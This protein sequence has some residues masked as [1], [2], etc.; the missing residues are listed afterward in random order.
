VAL[1]LTFVYAG[2]GAPGATTV[3]VTLVHITTACLWLGGLATL[4][5]ALVPSGTT[6]GLATALARFSFIAPAC[7]VVLAA[8]G[9]VHA[10]LR[11]GSAGRLFTTGYGHAY[12]LKVAAVVAM[13]AVA[14]GNRRYVARH[15]RARVGPDTAPSHVLG[16]YLGA[17]VAFGLLVVVLTGTLVDAPVT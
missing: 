10:V 4:A 1:A 16:L 7:V 15:V 12:W 6:A 5:V 13:L 2:P 8:T 14:N 9:T 11:A 17:E 3:G